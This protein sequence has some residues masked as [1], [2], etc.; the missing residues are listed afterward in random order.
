[1]VKSIFH[2]LIALLELSLKV[3]VQNKATGKPGQHNV[4]THWLHVEV[5]QLV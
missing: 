4:G 2:V 1:M 3:D 5:E